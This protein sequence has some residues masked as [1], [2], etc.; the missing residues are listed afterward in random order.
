MLKPFQLGASAGQLNDLRNL[1][2]LG[3]F[4]IKEISQ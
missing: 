1:R 3:N 4:K 2:N